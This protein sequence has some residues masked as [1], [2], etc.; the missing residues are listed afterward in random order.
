MCNYTCLKCYGD[1]AIDCATC[2]D[3]RILEL[4]DPLDVGTCNCKEN[5]FDFGRFDCECKLFNNFFIFNKIH[6]ILL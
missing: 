1:E 4:R 6:D 2:R 3:T 5:L